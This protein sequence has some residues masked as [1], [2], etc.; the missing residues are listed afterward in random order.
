MNIGVHRFFWIGVSGFL[1]YNPNS[2][3]AGSKGRSNFSFFEEIPSCFPQW[4]HQSTF[5]PTV[6]FPFSSSHDCLS[7]SGINEVKRYSLPT[8]PSVFIRNDSSGVLC[9]MH[10]S[11]D[12]KKIHIMTTSSI[13][14]LFS[15]LKTGNTLYLF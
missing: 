14:L 6:L 10:K 7:H 12:I 2:G 9:K 1:G 15:P 3:I 5:S 13:F 8:F 11:Y 4:L